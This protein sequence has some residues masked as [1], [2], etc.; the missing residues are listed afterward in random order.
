MSIVI[1]RKIVKPEWPIAKIQ[2][3]TAR[4]MA[5]QWL[6]AYKALS[7]FGPE[8]LKEFDKNIL[9]FKVEHYKSIGVKTPAEL[10]AAISEF[11]TN[12]FGSKIEIV[13]EGEKATMKYE[14][15]AIW[16][17]MRKVGN[18]TPEQEEKMGT[19]FET[20]M[21][22]LAREFGFKAETKYEEPCC[23]VTFSK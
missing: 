15:C 16:D 14:S 1:E 18:L 19:H 2:E 4:V 12:V 8:G 20:C 5:S 7:K 13:G 21:N 6:A 23:I 9:A 10:V 11:E 17:Q 3:S 22:D